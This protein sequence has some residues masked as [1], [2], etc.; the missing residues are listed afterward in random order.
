MMGF[1]VERVERDGAAEGFGRSLIRT[2]ISLLSEQPV[3]QPRVRFAGSQTLRALERLPTESNERVRRQEIVRD[4]VVDEEG[5]SEGKPSPRAPKVRCAIQRAFVLGDA[6]N[7]RVST[8]LDEKVAAEESL[9]RVGGDSTGPGG[10]ARLQASEGFARDGLRDFV[11]QS[12]KVVG[13]AVDPSAP[14]R[15]K[16]RSAGQLD[17]NSKRVP[18]PL[19]AAAEDEGCI[20]CSRNHRRIHVGTSPKS[21]ALKARRYTQPACLRQRP[22]DLLRQAGSEVRLTRVARQ[23]FEQEHRDDRRPFRCARRV[24]AVGALGSQPGSKT[25]HDQRRGNAEHAA[26]Y[27][28]TRRERRCATARSDP[29]TT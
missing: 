4:L 8:R 15:L 1:R 6:A 16:S 21:L 13:L 12:E 7:D 26:I 24:G 17:P 18:I 10:A 2:R 27:D 28:K 3:G 19:N 20:Q 22:N 9:E 5:V 14:Y 25:Q 23:V 29:R 11:Y